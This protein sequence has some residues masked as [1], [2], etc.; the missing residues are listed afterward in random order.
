MLPHADDFHTTSVGGHLRITCKE[1]ALPYIVKK[2]FRHSMLSYK[3]A[4]SVAR[5]S[6]AESV[7]YLTAQKYSLFTKEPN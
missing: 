5:L 3:K 2:C 1:F 6:E 4:L 7:A